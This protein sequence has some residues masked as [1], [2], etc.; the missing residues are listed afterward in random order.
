MRLAGY[1]VIHNILRHFSH[2]SQIK[3]DIAKILESER[4][5]RFI[6]NNEPIHDCRLKPR[7]FFALLEIL[8]SV[9]SKQLTDPDRQLVDALL[10]I[11][12]TFL[13]DIY[14]WMKLNH[15]PSGEILHIQE[16]RTLRI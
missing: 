12:P 14:V 9:D 10:G 6:K 2:Q 3:N 5:S 7:N 8:F 15:R 11:I 1:F 13:L 16:F 4:R